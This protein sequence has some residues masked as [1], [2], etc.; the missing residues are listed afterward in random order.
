MKYPSDEISVANHFLQQ[1]PCQLPPAFAVAHCQTVNNL[2]FSIKLN[3]YITINKEDEAVIIRRKG[4]WT[5]RKR[6]FR[7][8]SRQHMET[9][10][11]TLYLHV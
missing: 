1:I 6:M 10:R 8:V 11:M 4:D 3:C 9:G 2:L 7:A 5:G